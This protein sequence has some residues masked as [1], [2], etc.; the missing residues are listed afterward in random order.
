MKRII[1]F[2]VWDKLNQEMFI[3]TN[4]KLSDLVNDNTKVLLQFTGLKD[5]FNKE[6]FEG[7]IVLSKINNEDKGK[8]GEVSWIT[9]AEGYNYSGWTAFP[10][11]LPK[12]GENYCEVLGNIYQNEELL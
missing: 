4:E 7:D 8:I 1:K 11:K 2:K 3:L 10:A 9:G 5:K 6:I 12:G